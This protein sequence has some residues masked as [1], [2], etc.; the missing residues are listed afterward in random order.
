MNRVAASSSS[1]P[2]AVFR[3]VNRFDPELAACHAVPSPTRRSPRGVARATARSTS[4][5]PVRAKSKGSK[6]TPILATRKPPRGGSCSAKAS[7][8]ADETRCTCGGYRPPQ[9]SGERDRPG[10]SVH[11]RRETPWSRPLVTLSDLPAVDRGR[12]RLWMRWSPAA[13]SARDGLRMGS[14]PREHS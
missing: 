7:T 12:R 6:S 8:W 1:S 4:A 3:S 5:A 2:I 14:R 9:G 11:Q 10:D 13:P